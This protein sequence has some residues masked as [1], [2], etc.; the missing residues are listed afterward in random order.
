VVAGKEHHSE[1]WNPPAL[2][3]NAA[4]VVEVQGKVEV[5]VAAGDLVSMATVV[6]GIRW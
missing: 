1:S 4:E 2:P 6:V 5:S 3:R